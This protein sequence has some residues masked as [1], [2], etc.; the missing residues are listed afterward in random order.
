[1]ILRNPNVFV[2]VE[3][4]DMLKAGT[5]ESTG[6]RIRICI[7]PDQ[8]SRE[9]AILYKLDERLVGGNRGRTS[10]QAEHERPVSRR[11]EIVDA[12]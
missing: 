1:M 8:D 10:G 6:Q 3:C 2:H 9:F 7:D 4:Y 11:I 12:K 5:L